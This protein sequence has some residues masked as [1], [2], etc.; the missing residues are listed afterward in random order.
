[1]NTPNNG[2]INTN[3]SREPIGF[4]AE[5][6]TAQSA[7]Q[8]IHAT[9]TENLE[10]SQTFPLTFATLFRR[11]EFM[12]LDRMKVDLR[13][14]LH[15]DQEYQYVTA[16]QL[17]DVPDVTTKILTWKERRG[18]IF[19]TLETDIAVDGVRRVLATT[20]FVLRPASQSKAEK[21]DA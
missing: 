3:V 16:F 17:G 7:S 10:K 14:L 21:G 2:I 6:L 11:A 1:M 5:A 18:M 20:T 9:H 4:R 15:T 12:W 19:V 13:N 8:F